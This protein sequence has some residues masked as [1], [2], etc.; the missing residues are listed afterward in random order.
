M[1][2]RQYPCG[3][4]LLGEAGVDCDRGFFLRRPFVRQDTFLMESGFSRLFYFKIEPDSL[5][6]LVTVQS[7]G[8]CLLSGVCTG[9]VERY[10]RG[11][12]RG[13]LLQFLDVICQP[14]TLVRVEVECCPDYF[15]GST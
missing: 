1:S 6:K 2:E 14:S 15:G 13:A 11:E 3:V 12:S 9:Q 8:I 5:V 7:F 4:L 10:S